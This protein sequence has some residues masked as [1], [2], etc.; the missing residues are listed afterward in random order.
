MLITNRF[1]KYELVGIDSSF[2]R[3]C[4]ACQEFEIKLKFIRFYVDDSFL[5]MNSR[6]EDNFSIG[7][8]LGNNKFTIEREFNNDISFLDIKAI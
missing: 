8:N 4:Q 7:N 2:V 5:I 6:N 3:D 1:S